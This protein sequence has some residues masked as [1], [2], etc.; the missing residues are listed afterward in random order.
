M[1]EYRASKLP[2]EPIQVT[3]EQDANS[4]QALASQLGLGD[5]YT[6]TTSSVRT[7]ERELEEYI[8]APIWTTSDPLVFWVVSCSSLRSELL[9]LHQLH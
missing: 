3:I 9:C 7:V 6:A 5:A 1:S 8:T 4:L 2:Q